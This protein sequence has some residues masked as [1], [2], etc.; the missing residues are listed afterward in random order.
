[1]E[2]LFWDVSV[3][4]ST[5]GTELITGHLV[6]GF[7]PLR[8]ST[9]Q[10]SIMAKYPH[11]TVPKDNNMFVLASRVRR[12]LEMAGHSNEAMQYFDRAMNSH[13]PE[14]LFDY[15]EEMVTIV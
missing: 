8:S 14:E 9:D 13:S 11:I 12:A 10:R 3:T 6:V 1:M 2:R 15:S 4:G 7:D 5:P